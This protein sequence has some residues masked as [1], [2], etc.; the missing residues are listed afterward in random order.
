MH[1]TMM[2]LRK[3]V[4]FAMLVTL[5]LVAMYHYYYPRQPVVAKLARSRGG[6]NVRDPNL[7][8]QVVA[9]GLRFPTTMAFL[10]PNT[11]LD[12]LDLVKVVY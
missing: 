2:Y 7:K 10:G 4:L 9:S 3:S 11:I 1:S 6:I 8:A 5:I 12:K